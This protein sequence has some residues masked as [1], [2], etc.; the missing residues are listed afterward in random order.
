MIF[1]SLLKIII[2]FLAISAFSEAEEV[3]VVKILD[4]NL[5]ELKDGRKIKLA[6]V[7]APSISDKNSNCKADKK[8]CK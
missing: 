6:N 4:S 5:F 8:I 2:L 7:D 3:K 1:R